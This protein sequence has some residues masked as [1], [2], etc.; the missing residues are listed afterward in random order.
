MNSN[1]KSNI[2]NLQCKYILNIIIELYNNDKNDE[3]DRDIGVMNI[4]EKFG[5]RRRK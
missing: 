3:I 2:S 5:L 4:L 1:T